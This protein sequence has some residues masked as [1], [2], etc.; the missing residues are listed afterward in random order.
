MESAKYL[1]QSAQLKAMMTPERMAQGLGL[2]TGMAGSMVDFNL[3]M[4]PPGC[5]SH[6][7]LGNRAP[8]K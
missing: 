2:V 6:D 1:A 3:N 8:C 7:V 4:T 5:F